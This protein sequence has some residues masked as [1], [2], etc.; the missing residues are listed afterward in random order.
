MTDQ[1]GSAAGGQ[2]GADG[3]AGANT[4]PWYGA[5]AGDEIKGFVETKGWNGPGD[6]IKSYR[7]LEQMLGADKAGRGFVWPKDDADTEGWNGLYAKLGRPESADGYKLP[8]PEGAS[9]EFSKAIAPV[10]HQLGLSTKQAEGLAAFVNQYETEQAA[11]YETERQAKVDSDLA[12][13]K[14]ELGAAY[15]KTVEL[16]KRAAGSFG[17][18]AEQ[19]AGLEEVLGLK[20]TVELFAAIGAK[21]GEDTFVGGD[22]TKSGELSAAAAK[23]RFEQ[24]KG[25]QAWMAKLMSGDRVAVEEKERLDANM[26]GMSLA[27][28]RA[29]KGG[30]A[31]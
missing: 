23:Q 19:F 3:G 21:I 15:D 7:N 26:L 2:P 29:A 16:A 22:P 20:G 12:A 24:L 18:K 9:P 27:E 1:N 14:T 13:F 31:A 5:D 4:A 25:D 17:V 6:A 8:V 11:K 10:M 30:K 28:Y